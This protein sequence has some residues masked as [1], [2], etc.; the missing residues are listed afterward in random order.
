MPL[1]KVEVMVHQF[2][3]DG[4]ISPKGPKEGLKDAKRKDLSIITNSGKMWTWKKAAF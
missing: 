3:R 1:S 2:S 4:P